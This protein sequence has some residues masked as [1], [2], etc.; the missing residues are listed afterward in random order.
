[1][2]TLAKGCDFKPKRVHVIG[3]GVM[4]GDIAA[5]CALRG[6]IVTLEDREAK[7]I[8]PAIKRAHKLYKK[9]LRSKLK[10]TPVM[11]RLIP[12]VSGAG[13][14]TA[15]VI[16]EAIYENL[17][18]KQE[19]FKRLEKEAKPDA[20]LATNTSS[21]P[22][23]EINT[24]MSNPGRLVG[25][26]FFNPVAMMPLVEVVKGKKSSDETVKKALSFVVEIARQPIEVNS[27][28]GFLVNRVLMPYMMEAMTL[29]EE[30]VPAS[31]VDK[32][33]TNFGMPMGPVELADTVGLDI[34]LSVAKNLSEHFGGTIP[35]RLTKMVE[36]GNL[37][38]KSGKGFYYY[39]N[40]K[41]VKNK[42]GSLPIDKKDVEQR[43]VG[44]M[45]NE[46]VAC[47][48]E[49]VID[50]LNLLDGG[51]IFGTGFAPFT[52]GPI[53]YARDKGINNITDNLIKLQ[54][55]YGERFAPDA[56]WEKID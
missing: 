30:G 18:A 35:E 10:I 31:V 5:W 19:L 4:G 51:M 7:F 13:A 21:I 14:K 54:Q 16:I 3:A 41:T 8:A 33:A 50:D 20:I 28:P 42:A 22:L 55:K 43:L 44:R 39:K 46:A 1:M 47:Y 11:D 36:A 25:I 24:A 34:C 9:K 45:L 37:G 38:R 6:M 49:G 2:K 53:N 52:G 40:G 15:D 26:H 17:E 29:L 56:G 27:S 12:D 23:D 32:V 48:R